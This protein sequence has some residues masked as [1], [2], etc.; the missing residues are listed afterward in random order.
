MTAAIRVAVHMQPTRDENGAVHFKA[1]LPV[2]ALFERALD[3]QQVERARAELENAYAELIARLRLQRAAMRPENVM[4]YWLFG[5]ALVTF[6]N[7]HKTSLLFV[8]HLNDHLVRD[9]E[10]S[11]SMIILCRRFR[12]TFPDPAQVDPRQSFTNYQRARFDPARLSPIVRR[13][14]RPRIK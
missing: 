1:A 5:D 6:E 12:E 13:R 4:A 9:V 8:D 10:F 7:A 14:G 3:K 11:N 2:G